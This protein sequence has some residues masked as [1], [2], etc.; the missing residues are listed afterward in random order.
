V[1]RLQQVGRVIFQRISP[2]AIEAK[3]MLKGNDLYTGMRERAANLR[4]TVG[5]AL[6]DLPANLTGIGIKRIRIRN[7]GD[8]RRYAR[9]LRADCF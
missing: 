7:C 1:Q 3:L 5:V 2:D 8:P 9:C 6:L 4:I